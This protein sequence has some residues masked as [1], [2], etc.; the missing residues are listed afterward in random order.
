MAELHAEVTPDLFFSL[1]EI[2]QPTTIGTRSLDNKYTTGSIWFRQS[3]SIIKERHVRINCQ[4][5]GG[6]MPGLQVSFSF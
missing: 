3:D 2:D 1:R 5:A 6:C 4:T